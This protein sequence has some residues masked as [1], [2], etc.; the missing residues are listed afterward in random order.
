MPEL[1]ESYSG[2]FQLLI[3]LFALITALR[4]HLGGRKAESRLGIQEDHPSIFR[5]RGAS[6]SSLKS[7]ITKLGGAN[8]VLDVVVTESEFWIKGIWPM[9]S[10][11]ASRYDLLHR[12]PLARI[13]RKEIDGNVVR[14]TF[15]G[16]TDDE[17]IVELRLRNLDE[18]I[19]ALGGTA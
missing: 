12:V 13:L 18:F 16:D 3:L 10:Y 7:V 19:T 14:V 1:V 2:V 15:S 17:T 6:G 4:M 9:F 8:K 5:E 11:V